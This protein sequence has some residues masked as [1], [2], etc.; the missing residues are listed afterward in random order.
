MEDKKTFEL[1]NSYSLEEMEFL[2]SLNDGSDNVLDYE[3]SITDNAVEPEMKLADFN[4]DE[5]LKYMAENINKKLDYLHDL[6]G[7]GMMNKIMN[8]AELNEWVEMDEDAVKDFASQFLVYFDDDKEVDLNKFVFETFDAE[9]YKMKYPNF[10]DEWYEIMATASK[11]KLQDKRM[12][13]FTKRNEETTLNF[14]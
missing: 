3:Y 14:K 8:D 12:P 13:T 4:E 5:H 2:K 10:P 1:Q 6:S 9:Y 7:S 11:E